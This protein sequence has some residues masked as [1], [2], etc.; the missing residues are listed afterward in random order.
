[1]KAITSIT[2]SYTAFMSFGMRIRLIGF[3]NI[4]TMWSR[5]RMYLDQSFLGNSRN[6]RDNKA[7]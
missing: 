3:R 1:M 7:Q 2:A 5:I 6:K 4:F